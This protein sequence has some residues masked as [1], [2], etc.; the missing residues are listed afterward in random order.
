MPGGAFAWKYFWTRGILYRLSPKYMFAIPNLYK[1]VKI[2][3]VLY[4]IVQF[5]GDNCIDN[6][7]DT[8]LLLYRQVD[9]VAYTEQQI[10]PHID[11]T[12]LPF[13][14]DEAVHGEWTV[15][16]LVREISDFDPQSQRVGSDGL[17]TQS[18]NFLPRGICTKAVKSTAGGVVNYMLRYTKDTI[19]NDK[20][21][22]AESYIIKQI[23]GKE[24][25]FAEH[26]SGDYFY[27]GL[28]PKFYVFKRK[29]N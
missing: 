21:M 25:L 22:T 15:C 10:R 17:Y 6:G 12:N 24:F 26:K 5:I 28:S 16:D 19:L 3:G 20:E 23:D 8:V 1:T 27:G 14:D 2:D 13:V 18:I 9:N 29:D 7:D 11:N 4:M